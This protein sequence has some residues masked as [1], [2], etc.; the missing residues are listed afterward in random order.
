MHEIP[1]IVMFLAFAYCMLAAM[2]DPP[3]DEI[4][5]EEAVV[6]APEGLSGPPAKAVEMLVE[7]VEKRSQIR[8][9]VVHAWPAEAVPA[10]GVG[11]VRE[12]DA[13]AG[14]YAASF[15]DY[16]GRQRGW[17]GFRIRVQ[18]ERAAPAVLVVGNAAEGVP[19]GVGRLL[20]TLRIRRG[21]IRLP[22]RLEID[23]E[24]HYPVR[25]HQL[26][27]RPKTNSYDGWTLTM[28]EQYMRDLVVFGANAI[29]LIPPRSDDDA[30]SPHFPLPPME[31]M[32]GMSRIAGE[33]GMDV[34]IWYPA[35]DPDYADP[36]TVEFALQ[37]WGEVFRQLPQIDALFVP[38]GDPGH[39]PP[40]VL[41]ALLK[42]QAVVLRRFHR[43]A[44]VWVA[45]Q[46]FS[47][48]WLDEFVQVLP[49][50]PPEWLTGLVYGPQIRVSLPQLQAML[51]YY[52]IRHYP[53]I[54]HSFHCQYP[55]PDWDLAYALTEGREGI[56]PRPLGQAQIFRRLHEHTIG[57]I[58][59]SEGC[60]DDVNKMVWSALGW[61]PDA[62]VT[63][64]LRDY[65]R[66]FIGPEY[67]DAFAQGLLALERNWQGPLLTNEGV[68][69][70]LQQFQALERSASPQVRLNW[71][72]QQALYRAYY[73]AFLRSRLLYETH[74]EERAMASLRQAGRTGSLVAMAEAERIL[75][76]AV[77]HP[78]AVEWRAR[79]F[80]LA[81][82]LF[83]SIRMQ[84]SVPRYQAISVGR[85]ANLDTIDVPLNNAAWLK[86]Q[87]AEIRTRPD[88]ADRLRGID[89][90]LNWTNPGPGGFYDD[91]GNLTSQPHLVRG[92]G[93]EQ[94]PAFLESTLVG[95]SRQPHGRTSWCRHAESLNDAPLRMRY[96]DL[97]PNARYRLRVTYAG[98]AMRWKVRLVAGSG[99]E[100]H[101]FI[102]KPS[103]I[104]PLEF[105]VPPGAIEN[106]ELILSWCREPGLGGNGRGCQVAE[107]WLMRAVAEEGKE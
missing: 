53:D 100:V 13:F 94:D 38:G 16:P 19:F 14:P 2:A 55:V 45:P 84:L 96:T 95:F 32:I 6:V 37:E 73:D 64:V 75:E 88:E 85:G 74:L 42:K 103:P 41:L 46:G 7:E 57:F 52:P 47:Q 68:F 77:L 79:V 78:V 81:E 101:P 35:M 40:K 20:R 106:G 89:A 107:V 87:F 54:T 63:E 25:G 24:P 62:D 60:N 93:F 83:Q 43:A 66:Y 10:I 22:A 82:A 86:R 39:T 50:N 76:E 28:W 15:P 18:T 29:E 104:Q 70:T 4:S 44:Q 31:T 97:D 34:W 69:T 12:A 102:E 27:Y 90:V 51:P 99:L 23:T 80:E 92:P 26:G 3:A 105:D 65:G 71:R 58:T 48:E 91:L 49:R 9:P 98:D 11:A 8:W 59:Y 30:D 33:Y 21:S 56:N 72:F 5:L 36:A 17:D 1:L 61:D 67:A